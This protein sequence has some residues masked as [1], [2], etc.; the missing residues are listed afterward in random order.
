MNDDFSDPR[1]RLRRILQNERLSASRLAQEKRANESRIKQEKSLE[2]QNYLT[3]IK[4]NH[5]LEKTELSHALKKQLEE[6]KSETLIANTQLEHELTPERNK[7]ET[8]KAINLAEIAIRSSA[9]EMAITNQMEQNQ[10]GRRLDALLEE[11]LYLLIQMETEHTQ[12]MEMERLKSQL[13]REEEYHTEISIPLERRVHGLNNDDFDPDA[14]SEKIRAHV[15]KD[16]ET[17]D[18]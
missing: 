16:D 2:H 3:G 11:T 5:S 17:P 14:M 15:R 1:D 13:R 8:E 7:H 4:H 9:A 10:H 6:L 12:S 18:K